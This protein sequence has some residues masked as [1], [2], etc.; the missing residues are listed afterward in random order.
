MNI[1]VILDN[2]A[3]IFP[4]RPAVS[5]NGQE[6]SYSQFMLADRVAFGLVRLGIVPGEFIAICAPNSIEW[7]AV[8]FGAIK[9]GAVVVTLP[10]LLQATELRQLI[11]A[12]K[13]QMIFTIPERCRNS[14]SCAGPCLPSGIKLSKRKAGH[15][16]LL[17]L[18]QPAWLRRWSASGKN[19]PDFR[20][21]KL[22]A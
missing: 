3:L 22:T 11:D 15:G 7:I 2:S 21:T 5:Q 19:G 8:Y 9:A 1:S 16:P 6:I 10:G 12:S 4:D 17:F 14:I 13:P 20:F 18:R